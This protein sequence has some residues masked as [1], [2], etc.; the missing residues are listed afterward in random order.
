MPSRSKEKG[1]RFEREVVNIAKENNLKSERAYGSDGRALGENK[2]VDVIIDSIAKKWRIQVKVRKKIAQWIKPDSKSVDL[3]VVKEDRGEIYAVLPYKSFIDLVVERDY[4]LE[5]SE[6]F[7][8][9]A[10]EREQDEL[11]YHRERRQEIENAI[12]E[13]L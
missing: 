12:K 3:Q 8:D 2:E 5:N 1:N 10:R 7:K 4:L 6:E 9:S 13:S 11:E